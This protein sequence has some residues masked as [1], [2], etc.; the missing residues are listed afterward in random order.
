MPEAGVLGRYARLIVEVGANVRPGQDVL[1][2]CEWEHADL[3][4]AV[5]EAAYKVGAHHVDVRYRDAHVRRA[6]VELAAEDALDWTPPWLFERS[7]RLG[8]SRGAWIAL[9]G[10][11]EPDLLADLD[12]ARVGKAQMSALRAERLRILNEA[13]VN[14]TIV[15]APNAGWA[16]VVFGEPDVERLW[17]AV[18]H[19]VRLDEPDPVAA[20]RAH[21]DKLQARA[22]LLNAHRFDAIHYSGP[23]SDLTVGLAE[24]SRWQ[25]A[26]ETTVEGVV[27]APNLPTEEVFVSPDRNRAE[28][29]IRSTRPLLLGGQVVRDLEM[30]FQG[31]RCVEVR[32]SS[33]AEVVRAD[34]AID[35]GAA[36][37]GELAL[38][39]GDSRVAKAGITFY[40]TLFD[41]NATCHIAYG[42]GFTQ[43][44]EGAAELTPAERLA[45][46]L[47]DS[48]T[49]TDFMV[50]GPEVE[51]TGLTAGG[52]RV[53]IIRNDRW[54]LERPPT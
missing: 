40:D 9:H 2:D 30:A 50:G 25:A 6:H 46:G 15:G 7:R 5:T 18:A 26:Q 3:A 35:E 52:D 21:I 4:R 17:A 51:V 33:G 29:T 28:G 13:L 27:F 39:D 31:G 16:R 44:F 43:A 49:H 41:E 54:V 14:W 19:A 22:T 42:G 53:P 45:L 20:W 48:G 37:L 8:E 1:V 11:A 34:Q 38:V 24:R 10:E 36:R 32:A 12:P 23:G 47:N